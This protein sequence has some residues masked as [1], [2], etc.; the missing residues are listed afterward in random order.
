M[1]LLFI[2]LKLIAPPKQGALFLFPF[3]GS[4]GRIFSIKNI[5]FSKTLLSLWVMVECVEKVYLDLLVMCNCIKL[6]KCCGFSPPTF[7]LRMQFWPIQTRVTVRL[8]T[9]SGK[10]PYIR[11]NN[12]TPRPLHCHCLFLDRMQMYEEYLTVNNLLPVHDAL[13]LDVFVVKAVAAVFGTMSLHPG[14]HGW[15]STQVTAVLIAVL[16]KVHARFR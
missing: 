6:S 3:L 13:T 7:L 15:I 11:N 14:L 5:T 10:G 1:H 9:Y 12:M 8:D 4:F 16:G 2:V